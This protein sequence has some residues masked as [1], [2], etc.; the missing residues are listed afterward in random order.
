MQ[1]CEK[2]RWK[3]LRPWTGLKLFRGCFGAF[4]VLLFVSLFVSNFVLELHFFSGHF[5]SAEVPHPKK[6]HQNTGLVR[7]ASKSSRELRSACFPV[8]RVRNPTLASQ[9]IAIAEKSPSFSNRKAQNDYRRKIGRR[10]ARKITE[11]S[12]KH[13][14]GSEWKSQRFCVFKIAVFSGR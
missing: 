2:C 10:I 9:K 7:T 6:Y 13:F 4:V 5:R 12:Q 11:K 8:V 14:G 1:N 3:L